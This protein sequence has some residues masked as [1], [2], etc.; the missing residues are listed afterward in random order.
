[1]RDKLKIDARAAKQAE[2]INVILTEITPLEKAKINVTK[3]APK[4]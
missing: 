4:V 2:I 1:M 3:V